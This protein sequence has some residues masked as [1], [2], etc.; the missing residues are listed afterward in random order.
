MSYCRYCGKEITPSENHNCRKKPKIVKYISWL[1]DR[2]GVENPFRNR[3]EIYE[4]GQKVTPDNIALDNGEIPVKQY[5]VGI[6]RSRMRFQRSEGRLQITNKRVLFRATGYSPAGKTTYQ[7]AFSLDKI[8]GVE[9]H[10]DRRFRVPDF[11]FALL[12]DGLSLWFAVLGAAFIYG[13][14]D[15]GTF[16]QIIAAIL[17]AAVGIGAIAHFFSRRKKFFSKLLLTGVARGGVLAL[18]NV[19]MSTPET[20]LNDI[21][22]SPSV[23]IWAVVYIVLSVLYYVSMFL[24][25]VKPNLMIEIKT[26]SGSPGIQ[27]KHKEISFIWHKSEEFSGFTEILPWKDTDLAIKEVAT[28]IDDIKTLGDFGVEK[29]RQR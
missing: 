2:S 15:L 16:G 13:G 5:N 22:A 10:K 9:I 11:L 23:V 4:R 27:I 25:V 24:F 17:V 28:I 21:I 7:H 20:T 8:D 1:F 6:L 12:W 3:N 14:F 29:W 19:I 18:I 26:S